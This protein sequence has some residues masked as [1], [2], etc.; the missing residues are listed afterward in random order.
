MFELRAGLDDQGSI[1]GIQFVSRS[2]SGGEITRAFVQRLIC[3]LTYSVPDNA[4]HSAIS[5]F[6]IERTVRQGTD[7]AVRTTTP[8]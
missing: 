3:V 8:S 5:V 6:V 4:F 2:F 1:S 7:G